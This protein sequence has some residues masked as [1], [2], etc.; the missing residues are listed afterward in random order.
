M[1][2]AIPAALKELRVKAKE[3]GVDFDKD[4]TEAELSILVSSAEAAA[5]ARAE[6]AGDVPP[7]PSAELTGPE[8]ASTGTEEVPAP[9]GEAQAFDGSG[10]E[11]LSTHKSFSL[12]RFDAKGKTPESFALRNDVG[13][14]LATFA[15]REEGMKHMENLTR[16]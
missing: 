5:K 15:S 11:V 12:V 8:I 1:G 7:A 14:V 3:L 6:A 2:K 4:T 16:F 13:Q 9:Q 10:G